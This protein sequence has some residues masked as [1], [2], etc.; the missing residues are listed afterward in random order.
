[1]EEGGVANQGSQPRSP[2]PQGFPVMNQIT[3]ACQA[4][5]SLPGTHSGKHR[6]KY[7]FMVTLLMVNEGCKPAGVGCDSDCHL[8]HSVTAG[9]FLSLCLQPPSNSLFIIYEVKEL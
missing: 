8:G 6:L 5:V 3:M 2:D 4:H 9:L 1:M 7:W